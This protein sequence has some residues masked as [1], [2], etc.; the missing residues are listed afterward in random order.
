MWHTVLDALDRIGMTVFN[1]R[2]PIG[3]LWPHILKNADAIQLNTTIN[4]PMP[5]IV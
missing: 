2:I 4:I 3:L 5:T 1:A